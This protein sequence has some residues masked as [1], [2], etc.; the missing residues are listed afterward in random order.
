MGSAPAP[1]RFRPAEVRPPSRK[2]PDALKCI[3]RLCQPRAFYC[4]TRGA[5]RHTRGRVCSHTSELGFKTPTW[6]RGFVREPF[7]TLNGDSF[8]VF[9]VAVQLSNHA[10]R[11]VRTVYCHE[12]APLCSHCPAHCLEFSP[13]HAH[14]ADVLPGKQG[15]GDY[16][17]LDG[18]NLTWDVPGPT[19][20]Q[21][22]PIGNGDIG[23]NVWVE[24]NGDL[25]F[26]I[27]KTDAWG[28]DVDGATG[29]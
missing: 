10:S 20:L 29:D 28:Q 18:Y 15:G 19:S 11:V 17:E 9:E 13:C 21:S 12:N 2:T 1:A 25:L 3:G 14:R 4:G 7:W 22:M 8:Q 16:L 5:F 23:L 24:T 26:Y 27:G 6:L